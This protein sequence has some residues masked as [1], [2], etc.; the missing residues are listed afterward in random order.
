MT[1]WNLIL[2]SDLPYLSEHWIDGLLA[3]ALRSKVQAF[4]PRNLRG[5]E[6]LAA[7][8]RRDSRDLLAEAFRAGVRKVTD[9]LARISVET[10]A[11]EDVGAFEH[12]E[13]VLKNMN[14][15]GTSK[16]PERGGMQEN[17]TRKITSGI[18]SSGHRCYAFFARINDKPVTAEEA[19]DRH[20]HFPGEFHRCAGKGPAPRATGPV[21][22][23]ASSR[24]TGRR[25]LDAQAGADEPHQSRLCRKHHRPSLRS[26]VSRFD[27]SRSPHRK[28]LRGRSSLLRIA[29]K[30][31]YRDPPKQVEPASR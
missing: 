23:I 28:A 16:R 9:A 20:P 26:T 25:S 22:R 11:L 8:Y 10:E 21:K 19:N 5:L 18:R 15:P 27:A 3:R 6:P 31:S 2:A 1:D 13:L 14:T 4:V 24:Q 17:S 29:A 12:N 30:N 7:V